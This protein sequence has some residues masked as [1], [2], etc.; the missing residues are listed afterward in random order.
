[1]PPELSAPGPS[2]YLQESDRRYAPP[3]LDGAADRGSGQLVNVDSVEHDNHVLLSTWGPL[4]D[5]SICKA[6]V[7]R[8]V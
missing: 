4:H 3:R 8:P 7:C 1:M 6:K 5:V 2:T